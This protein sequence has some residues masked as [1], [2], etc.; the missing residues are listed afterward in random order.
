MEKKKW[1]ILGIIVA[2]VLIPVV[3]LIA[4]PKNEKKADT[5]S[6]KT[7][8]AA[9]SELSQILENP[10]EKESDEKIK[11]LIQTYYDSY[12]SGDVETLEQIAKPFSE[13]EKAFV[14]MF[15]E[16]V[17]DY[18]NLSCYVKPVTGKK[19]WIVNADID[20]RFAGVDTPAPGL[21]FFYVE[22]DEND[23]IFINN[24]YCQYNSLMKEEDVDSDIQTMIREFEAQED[25]ILLQNDVEERYQAAVMSDTKLADL[26]STTIHDAYAS[27][28]AR[29][30]AA[31][32]DTETVREAAAEAETEAAEPEVKTEPE[33]ETETETETKTEQETETETEKTETS[34][35]PMFT[36]G[37]KIYI[38][39]E[40]STDAKK[41]GAAHQDDTVTVIKSYPEGWTEVEWEGKTGFIRSDLLV[42]S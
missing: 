2:A 24:R 42:K 39:M 8:A 16:Y 4:K 40:M 11:N 10:L 23:T 21:D 33:T 22:T 27:W 28:A 17:D 3:I 35:V 9:S 20:I 18:E 15:S 1:I 25:V 26:I 29:G 31:E 41:V 14:G 5:A 32:P 12:A 6:S 34:D 37:E 30:E 38:R 19:A 36:P 7:T 13:S